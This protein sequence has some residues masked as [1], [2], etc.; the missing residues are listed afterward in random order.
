ML[1]GLGGVYVS[2]GN[3]FVLR[4]AFRLSGFEKNLK[5]DVLKNR[6][7]LHRI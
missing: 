6:F 5:R 2:G 4:Q 7:P 1:Q 3:T